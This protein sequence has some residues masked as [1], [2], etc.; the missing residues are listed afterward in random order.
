MKILVTGGAGFIGSH[1]VN[2][3]IEAGHEVVV[4]DNL[5]SGSKDRIHPKA[6]FYFM[7]IRSASLPQVF[8]LEKPDVV[9]H[10]AAQKSVPKSVE[11]PRLDADY[12]VTGLLN[13]L[14]C[15]RHHDVK[16]FIF[17]SSGG[18]LAGDAPMI[19]TDESVNPVMISPYAIHKYVGEKY[20]HFYRVT[21]N[22]R[23]TVLRYANVY[24]PNQI[25]DGECGV[26]P[27]FMNNILADQ[28]STLFAYADEP[29][30]TTR[31]YVYVKDVAEANVLALTAAD[32]EILNIGSGDG[33][34]TADVYHL[35]ARIAG[36]NAPLHR[37]PER[38]GD[39]RRSVLDCTRA[40]QVLGWQ[41]RTSLETGIQTTLDWLRS[42]QA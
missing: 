7:D 16:K 5:S 27:I 20:L 9:N 28:P 29:R 40:K 8:T 38:V 41:P 23:Y 11:D 31:D 33:I 26:I 42:R 36:S 13:L 34:H 39:V 6:K 17:I 37:A 12:N 15:C 18:A 32:D 10:H 25:A 2:A 1:V 35:I 4:I 21:Y 24:G 30:G 14:E 22:L 19:P 3:Y